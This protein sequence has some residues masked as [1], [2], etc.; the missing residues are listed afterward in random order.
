MDAT[1]LCAEIATFILEAFPDFQAQTVIDTRS[2]VRNDLEEI[3]RTLETLVSTE[4][5]TTIH[6]QTAQGASYLAPD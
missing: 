6:M 4:V 1:P 3:R 5:L 2:H